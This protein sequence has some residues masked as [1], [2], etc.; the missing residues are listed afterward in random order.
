MLGRGLA[1]VAC[2]I[3][4][5]T[6]AAEFASHRSRAGFRLAPGGLEPGHQLDELLQIV[7]PEVASAPREDDKGILRG[8]VRPAGRK[9]SQRAGRIVKAHTVL[10]PGLPAVEQ[11]KRLATQGVKRMG[12][13]KASDWIVWNVC[14]RLL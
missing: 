4:A 7:H 5:L 13:P 9:V 12:D 11:P 6:E 3:V 8:D 2:G 10:T 14:S 1:A